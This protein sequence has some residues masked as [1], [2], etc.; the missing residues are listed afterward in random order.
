MSISVHTSIC[1]P[2]IGWLTVQQ[3]RLHQIESLLKTVLYNPRKLA[4]WNAWKKKK[5]QFFMVSSPLFTPLVRV[6]LLPPPSSRC[7]GILW[8]L[9]RAVME[10]LCVSL[11]VMKMGFQQID[12]KMLEEKWNL[13]VKQLRKSMACY[14]WGLIFICICRS[15]EMV[16]LCVAIHLS[17]WSVKYLQMPKHSCCTNADRSA[18]AAALRALS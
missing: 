12:G 10:W 17:L 9:Q 15:S 7:S 5:L 3:L 2:V 13:K 11:F 16:S 18:W 1:G 14:R 8:Q 4:H 6:I